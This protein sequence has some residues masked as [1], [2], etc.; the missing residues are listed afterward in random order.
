Q[1][2]S[3][4]EELAAT[5][6]EM[7]GQ[8]EQLQQMMNFFKIASD[9]ERAVKD[10]IRAPDARPKLASKAADKVM[11]MTFPPSSDSEFVAF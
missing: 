3:A 5:A 7:S 8:A 6:E 1:N 11:P 4:S 2:A 9:V 10:R